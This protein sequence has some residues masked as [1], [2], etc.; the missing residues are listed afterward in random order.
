MYIHKPI[1]EHL[2]FLNFF[3]VCQTEDFKRFNKELEKETGRNFLSI[4]KEEQ[5]ML[6]MFIDLSDIAENIEEITE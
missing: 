1:M 4:L 6:K 5:E 2:N 3:T